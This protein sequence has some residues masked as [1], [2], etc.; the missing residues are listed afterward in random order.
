MYLPD[1]YIV[2]RGD[3]AR[4]LYI[5]N[6]GIC[7]VLDPFDDV[8]VRMHVLPG[9]SFGEIGV[10]SSRNTT[11]R[12]SV[13]ADGLSEIHCVTRDD[14]I[15]LINS[16]PQLRQNTYQLAYQRAQIDSNKLSEYQELH[17]SIHLPRMH[18]ENEESLSDEEDSHVFEMYTQQ[19]GVEGA[20]KETIT[21]MKRKTS[22]LES[23]KSTEEEEV[24]LSSVLE[25][26]NLLA[27]RLSSSHVDDDTEAHL[28][29]MWEAR[30][31]L[32]EVVVKLDAML[33][34]L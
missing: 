5:L 25:N 22:I 8:T 21:F 13:V 6:K 29:H 9:Q 19:P 32:Q 11:R 12:C 28:A 4:A 1:D 24:T 2:Y 15:R 18:E 26:I 27:T 23:V 34:T 7:R 20:R 33:A 14:F 31:N 3:P 30:Q 17:P 10:I 16:Y